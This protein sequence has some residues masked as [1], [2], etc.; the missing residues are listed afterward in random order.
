MVRIFDTVTEKIEYLELEMED[1]YIHNKSKGPNVSVAQ[2]GHNKIVALC[3]ASNDKGDSGQP[4]LM[5]FDRD[6]KS[7]IVLSD[8]DYEIY[9]GDY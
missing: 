4:L 9:G 1:I 7:L 8:F 3:F 6:A 2:I 5:Q